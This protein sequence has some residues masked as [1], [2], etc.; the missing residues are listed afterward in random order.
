MVDSN[1][2]MYSKGSAGVNVTV[3]P[4]L[5]LDALPLL[6]IQFVQPS[7]PVVDI[8]PAA[9][10]AAQQEVKAA[11]KAAG[12]KTAEKRKDNP[13][14]KK[15]GKKAAAKAADAPTKA[16]GKK[17]AHAVAPGERRQVKKRRMLQYQELKCRV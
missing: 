13:A 4:A 11:A 16:A 7:Q 15:A 1:R 12:K 2:D 17:A 8:P 9:V 10:D 14:R 5:T 3:Q 6:F